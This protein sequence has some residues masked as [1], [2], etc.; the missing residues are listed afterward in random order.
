MLAGEQ[1]R[2]EEERGSE[3]ALSASHVTSAI[4]SELCIIG[5]ARFMPRLIL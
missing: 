3:C 4:D 2:R 1:L 5:S